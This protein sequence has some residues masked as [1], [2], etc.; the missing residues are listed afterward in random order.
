MKKKL[1]LKS[2]GKNKTSAMCLKSQQQPNV[3]FEVQIRIVYSYVYISIHER[4]NK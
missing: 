3:S 4:M 1:F 2:V